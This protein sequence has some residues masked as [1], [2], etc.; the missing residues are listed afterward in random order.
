MAPL[1]RSSILSLD[2]TSTRRSPFG[3][4]SSSMAKVTDVRGLALT[5]RSAS[6]SSAK[7]DKGGVFGVK[8]WYLR[9]CLFGTLDGLTFL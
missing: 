8:F 5:R 2:H 4:N 9:H 3:L 6:V 7:S 1:L